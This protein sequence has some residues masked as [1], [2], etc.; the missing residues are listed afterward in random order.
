MSPK[1]T[2]K[3]A[4]K[5]LRIPKAFHNWALAEV[6][7]GKV[8]TQVE[9]GPYLALPILSWVLDHTVIIA[10]ALL[11]EGTQTK[12]ST[13]AM[14]FLVTPRTEN[15]VVCAMQAFG[16]TGHIWPDDKGWPS[17]TPDAAPIWQLVSGSGLAATFT[18]PPT[19]RG[20][21]AQRVNVK[22]AT[23]PFP[24]A[25]LLNPATA[26][27]PDELVAKLRQLCLDPSPFQGYP[28]GARDA[29]N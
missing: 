29:M 8:H 21:V 18:F 11:D 19:A 22:S 25:P 24:L 1:S 9:P 20:N 4:P 27:A 2:Q 23:E 12:V 16:W 15:Y 13:L 17:G 5:T 7:T 14:T 28:E 6:P 10:A 26:K 3:T